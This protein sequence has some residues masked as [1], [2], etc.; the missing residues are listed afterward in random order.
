MVT[1]FPCEVILTSASCKKGKTK[2][3]IDTI[4]VSK[5]TSGDD[6]LHTMDAGRCGVNDQGIGMDAG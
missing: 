1:L 5:W 3:P 6:R 2:R 4:C